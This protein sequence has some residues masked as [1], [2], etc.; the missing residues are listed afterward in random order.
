MLNHVSNYSTGVHG[1]HVLL[2]YA[3]CRCNK[4]MN[5][6]LIHTLLCCSCVFVFPPLVLYFSHRC[7]IF[8]NFF[9]SVPVV[10]GHLCIYSM[11]SVLVASAKL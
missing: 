3:C 6:I 11:V 7:S 10:C 8:C 4:F 5:N 9:C 2:L 1:L